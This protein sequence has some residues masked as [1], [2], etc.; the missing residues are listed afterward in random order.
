[1]KILNF[2]SCNIDNV[3]EIDHIVTPGETISSDS[4]THFPG[5]KG[6]NQSVAISRSGEKVYHAGCIGS[7]GGLLKTVLIDAGV[8]VRYLKT[9]D[10][11][12]GCAIIQ[13]DPR[14][15]NSIILY[16]GANHA[17]DKPYID[18]VISEF[19]EGDILVLQNE[20]SN[21]DYIIKKA[22]QK[23]MKI[24]LNP[25]PF[26]DKL[27]E[28]D[29]DD[30][31]VLILNEVEASAFAGAKDSEAICDYFASHYKNLEVVLTLGSRGAVY[32]G[33]NVRVSCPSYQV[34]VED[35]TAAGD[36][37]TGY[38][39]SAMV[40]K[41]D[42]S[43]ALKRASAAAAIAVS[44]KGAASSIPFKNE[45]DEKMPHLK[46]NIAPAKEEKR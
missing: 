7:D 27:R 6:L 16:P 39:I 9:V 33:K 43:A 34:E 10:T 46:A 1:L 20:I 35:T 37:F 11:P 25:S 45:V 26:E 15:E 42:V 2:G 18:E 14:G 32:V 23:K 40:N 3:Y 17:I 12:T 44:K 22:A 28:I 13:L 41:T 24:V 30:I 8:D 36:T 31:S 19:D 29:L 4:L 21:L 38:F 5:G